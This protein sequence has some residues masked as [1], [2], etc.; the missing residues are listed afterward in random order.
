MARGQLKETINHKQGNMVPPEPSNN[1]TARSGHTNTTETQENDF[2]FYS[3]KMIQA[4]K[5]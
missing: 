1:S 4:F 3:M 5:E 2:K